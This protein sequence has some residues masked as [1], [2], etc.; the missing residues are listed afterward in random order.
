[1]NSNAIL[2]IFLTKTVFSY[3]SDLAYR[4]FNYTNLDLSSPTFY[5]DWVLNLMYVSNNSLIYYKSCNEGYFFGYFRFGNISMF[6]K[7]SQYGSL[8]FNFNLIIIKRTIQIT[9]PNDSIWVIFNH[10]QVST[11]INLQSAVNNATLQILCGQEV[12]VTPISAIYI[13]TNALIYSD[14]FMT[15][16]SNMNSA[17]TLDW[18]I[19]GL[20]VNKVSCP[21]KCLICDY[22]NCLGCNNNTSFENNIC[23]CNKTAGWYDMGGQNDTISCQCKI[24]L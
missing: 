5:S 23:V 9:N 6:Y 19:N 12:Y 13:N 22:E 10:V 14:V 24:I 11:Q 18:G 3:I 7:D 4:I 20:Y 2:L 17:S 21:P 8:G 16:S 15:I 1:M